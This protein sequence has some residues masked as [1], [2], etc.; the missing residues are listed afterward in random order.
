MV[1]Y[2]LGVTRRAVRQ[3]FGRSGSRRASRA[4][5]SASIGSDFPR[6][7]AERRAPAISLV[8][9]RTTNAGGVETAVCADPVGVSWPDTDVRTVTTRA[10][11][12]ATANDV[13]VLIPNVR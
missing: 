8:C 10:V 4:T 6:S 9:T 5:A 13:L 7:R 11:Q 12:D 3:A 1:D 2:Q